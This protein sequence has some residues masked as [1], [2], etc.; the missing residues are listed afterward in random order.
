MAKALAERPLDSPLTS[1][2][3]AFCQAYVANG[4]NGTQAAIDAEY[5]VAGAS[6]QASRMLRNAK[7]IAR[8]RELQRQAV[9]MRGDMVA[10]AYLALDDSLAV[11]DQAMYAAKVILDQDLKRS[12]LGLRQTQAENQVKDRVKDRRERTLDRKQHAE[13]QAKELA[14][15]ER[16]VVLREGGKDD[17]GPQLVLPWLPRAEGAEDFAKRVEARLKEQADAAAGSG[18]TPH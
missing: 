4:G 8:V 2:Q 6:V 9:E 16:M 15:K 5:S 3:E 11:P 17:A 18:P 7:V 13:H 10:K 12:E 14:L 1:R